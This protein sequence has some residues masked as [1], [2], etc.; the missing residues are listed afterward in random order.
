MC[1]EGR[2]GVGSGLGEA[3]CRA[4]NK[5]GGALFG[6]FAGAKKNRQIGR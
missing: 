4:Q 6:G 3:G 5:K 2:G 1:W